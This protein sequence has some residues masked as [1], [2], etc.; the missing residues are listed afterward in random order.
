MNLLHLKHFYIARPGISVPVCSGNPDYGVSKCGHVEVWVCCALKAQCIIAVV[1]RGEHCR[2]FSFQ[3]PVV[4]HRIFLAPG[5]NQQQGFPHKGGD[6]Q[7]GLFTCPFSAPDTPAKEI[8]VLKRVFCTP[9]SACWAAHG[10]IP[11]SWVLWAWLTI[12]LL[13]LALLNSGTS[14]PTAAPQL[15]RGSKLSWSGL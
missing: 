7:Q 13:K 3:E 4:G 14:A 15:L 9:V 6:T 10:T 8:I 11:S 12:K 1:W 5:A 2:A